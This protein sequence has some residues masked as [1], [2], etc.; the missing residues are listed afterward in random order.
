MY[1]EYL[2]SKYREH[3]FQ[4]LLRRQKGEIEKSATNLNLN[5]NIIILAAPRT[6]QI[7]I[8]FVD[9]A[10]SFCIET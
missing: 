6:I 10:S 2:V 9:T 3:S 1:V 8:H 5:H 4:S 7:E